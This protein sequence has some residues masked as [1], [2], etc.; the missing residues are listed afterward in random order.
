MGA[1]LAVV[2]TEGTAYHRFLTFVL[3]SL[4]PLEITSVFKTVFVGVF[5]CVNASELI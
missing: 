3:L 1:G 4:S 2:L 5:C